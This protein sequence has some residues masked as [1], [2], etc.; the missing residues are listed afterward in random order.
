MS[1]IN[2]VSRDSGPRNEPTKKK[3][4]PKDP[5]AFKQLLQVDKIDPDEQSKRRRSRQEERDTE[6]P[7]EQIPSTSSS[8]A[9]SDTSLFSLVAKRSSS[10]TDQ[11]SSTE[12]SQYN[13]EPPSFE[14]VLNSLSE[15]SPPVEEEPPTEEEPQPSFEESLAPDTPAYYTSQTRSEPTDP[16][17][18]QRYNNAEKPSARSQQDTPTKTHA[19]NR[20]KTVN[21]T[22]KKSP[23]K[24]SSQTVQTKKT[25]KKPDGSHKVSPKKKMDLNSVQKELTPTAARARKK[26]K[27][28]EKKPTKIEKKL[29]KEHETL[30]PLTKTPKNLQT[31]RQDKEQD[32]PAL[33]IT[34]PQKL[35]VGNTTMEAS[36]GIK[37]TSALSPRLLQLLHNLSGLMTIMQK[38]GKKELSIIL[39]GG[40]PL[41]HGVKIT[42]TEWSSAPCQFNISMEGS[43]E[44]IALLEQNVEDLAAAFNN[45]KFSFKVH[46]IT[47]SISQKTK[48]GRQTKQAITKSGTK[49]D[50]GDQGK[51]E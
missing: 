28:I 26:T 13:T 22:S 27:T 18:P 29:P 15:D 45:G 23:P 41:L 44:A 48:D 20:T 46:Q 40:N 50:T 36:S 14:Q 47:T 7:W 1:N 11:S 12:N 10:S 19:S 37:R 5:D 25:L 31:Q 8:P 33:S 42:L 49:K 4:A 39:K 6:T 43:P 24:G 30:E 3:K 38:Q 34:P 16:P 21:S 32:A 35:S 51:E 2:N 9:S 17:S